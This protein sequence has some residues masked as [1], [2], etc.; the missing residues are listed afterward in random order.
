MTANYNTIA[1]VYKKSKEL[2]FRLYIEAYT[3]F[4]VL[5]NLGEKSLLFKE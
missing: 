4:N 1:L 5:G 3:F 2:P